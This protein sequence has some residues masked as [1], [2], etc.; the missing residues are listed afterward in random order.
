VPARDQ[1]RPGWDEIEIV[2]AM[3]REGSLAEP[4]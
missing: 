2:T 1:D 4:R 3:I